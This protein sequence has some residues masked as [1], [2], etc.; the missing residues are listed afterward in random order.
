MLRIYDLKNNEEI[1]HLDKAHYNGILSVEFV[2]HT[3]TIC[4]SGMDSAIKYWDTRNLKEPVFSLT[5]NSHWVWS[6]KHNKVYNKFLITCSSNTLVK[7]YVFKNSN[8]SNGFDFRPIGTVSE[9]DYNEFDDSVYA[10]DWANNDPW[11]FAGIVNNTFMHVNVLPDSFR[12]QAL[13]D[14]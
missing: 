6:T 7:C 13:L 8:E 3:F 9:I 4:T 5:N 1:S 10:I 2:P 12:I 11:T 14:K